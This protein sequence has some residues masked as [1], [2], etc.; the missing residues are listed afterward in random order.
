MEIKNV[1]SSLPYLVPWPP[2]P[3]PQSLFRMHTVGG[4]PLPPSLAHHQPALPL[5]WPQLRLMLDIAKHPKLS[6]FKPLLCLHKSGFGWPSLKIT[7]LTSG[8]R[9]GLGLVFRHL[10][11]PGTP[12][13]TWHY[14]PMADGSTLAASADTLPTNSLPGERSHWAMSNISGGGRHVPQPQGQGLELRKDGGWIFEKH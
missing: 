14:L 13:P 10:L 6:N 9:K 5:L 8:S 11:H 12:G 3:C 1:F 7:D 4:P 2:H